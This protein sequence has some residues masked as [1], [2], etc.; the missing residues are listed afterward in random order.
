L[1]DAVAE[2]VS[3]YQTSHPEIADYSF[4]EDAVRVQMVR[5]L[6]EP[7]KATAQTA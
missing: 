1:R 4:T 2:G 3:S 7:V 5:L 6:G